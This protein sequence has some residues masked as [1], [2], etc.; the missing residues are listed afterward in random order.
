MPPSSRVLVVS[1]FEALSM[2]VSEDR[3]Y[4]VT[5]LCFL[6]DETVQLSIRLQD[7]DSGAHDIL[8]DVD[9]ST[10]GARATMVS[11]LT[12]ARPDYFILDPSHRA[13]SDYLSDVT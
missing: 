1:D 10:P 13:T 5:D 2:S 11:W 4:L 6:T 7:T 3:I 12:T 9:V 8:A